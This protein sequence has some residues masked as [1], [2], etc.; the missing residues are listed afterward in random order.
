MKKFIVGVMGPGQS[1][2]PETCDE[3]RKLGRL[4][5]EQGWAVLTGGRNQGVMDAACQG[6][7]E[8]GGLTIGIIPVKDPNY[9]SDAVDV[10][11]YTDIGLARNNINVMSSDVVVA[12]AAG[13]S[14]G[15]TSE[16]ALGLNHGKYVIFLSCGEKCLDFFTDLEPE[17]VKVAES[18]EHVV[19]LINQLLLQAEL[20]PKI[21][22]SPL[23]TKSSAMKST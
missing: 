11:I 13:K 2:T 23:E 18:P 22:P 6:A 4:L 5:A 15:T 10:P 16:I 17:R 19:E 1:A 3:A 7:K 8:A 21:F 12:L 14:C 9:V 20:P